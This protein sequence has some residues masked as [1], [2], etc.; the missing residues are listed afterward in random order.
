MAFSY[1]HQG[2]SLPIRLDLDETEVTQPCPTCER[3]GLEGSVTIT[4][5]ADRKSG[6]TPA[7]CSNGHLIMVNW[8][9]EASP[10]TDG[11]AQ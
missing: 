4:A 1:R 3:A 10:D 7:S 9:R 11:P 5:A 2:G 6:M 8:T